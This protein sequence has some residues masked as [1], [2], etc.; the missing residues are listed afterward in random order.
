MDP[1]S[2]VVALGGIT[3]ASL[4][5]LSLR[6]QE[7]G[8][9]V[10][11]A[12]PAD[13]Y[14]SSVNESQSRYNMLTSLVNPLIN[15]LIPV[16][17]S[18]SE[19]DSTSRIVRQALGNIDAEYTNSDNRYTLDLKKLDNKYKPRSDGNDSIF[20]AINFC[21]K[22]GANGTPF[23]IYNTDGTVRREGA[24]SADGNFVFDEICGVCLSGGFDEEGKVFRGRRGLILDPNTRD[25]A[26]AD[27]QK[28]GLPYPRASPSLATCEGAPDKPVFATN[29]KDLDRFAKRLRCIAERNINPQHECGLCFQNDS[30][31]YVQNGAEITS[32]SLVLQ[33]FGQADVLLK[34]E[35]LQTITLDPNRSVKVELIGGKESDIFNVSV[36]LASNAPPNSIATVFGYIE[37]ITANGGSFQM[38]LNL[39]M[40]LDEITGSTPRKAG[41]F[42]NYI[43]INLDVAK[44]RPSAG[45]TRMNLRGTIP[46]T[47]VTADEFSA[48]D[49]P[50][51]PYQTNTASVSNFATD[52]PCY[53]KGSGPGKYND[54]CLRGRILD[55]GCTNKGTLYDDP[56][57]LNTNNGTNQN[58]TQIYTRLTN[59]YENDMIDP[60]K[61]KMCSGRTIDTPCDPFMAHPTL[62][63]T[64][65]ALGQK[66]VSFLYKNMGAN[67]PG[68]VKRIGP[69]YTAAIT[70]ANNQKVEKN[71]YCLP[72][73]TLNP[74]TNTTSLHTL[75]QYA[76]NG[77][78]GK[79]SVAAIKAYLNDQ[80]EIAIDMT[81]NANTDP[82]RKAAITRC[83]GR[84]LRSLPIPSQSKPTVTSIPC[85]VLG[86]Y[87]R[88]L[89]SLAGFGDNV[90]QIAQLVVIDKTGVNVAKGKRTTASA[91]WYGTAPK[92]RAN[93]GVM[94]ARPYDQIYHSQNTLPVGLGSTNTSVFW[95]V[96]L[97]SSLDITKII[98][99]NRTDCCNHRARGMRIQILDENMQIQGEQ[100]LPS[101]ELKQELNF[102]NSGVDRNVCLSDLKRPPEFVIPGGHKPGMFV[103]FYRC[104]SPNPGMNIGS[105]GWGPR[106]GTAN[107]YTQIHFQDHNL[108]QTDQCFV[109]AKG[110]FVSNGDETLQF[111]TISD[112]GIL[113][114]FNNQ[115]VISNWNIHGPTVNFSQEVYVEAPGIYP[116]ELR[117]YE[118]GGG[119]QCTLY[120]KTSQT[121]WSI[122]LNNRVYYKE[123]EVRAEEAAHQD[124]LNRAA[125]EK[126]KA[127][128]AAAAAKP[129]FTRKGCWNDTPNRALSGLQQWGHTPQSCFQKAMEAGV[130]QFALQAGSWCALYQNGNNYKRYGPSR[131]DCGAGGAGYVNTV[132]QINR[133]AVMYGSWIGGDIPVQNVDIDNVGNTVYMIEHDR[134]TKMVN[135]QGQAR[136]YVGS[137]GQYNSAYWN[138]YSRAD[139]NYLVRML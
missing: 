53:A 83:F 41:G 5:G 77:Y 43:D 90:I 22:E 76:D 78:N 40:V 18:K 125:A 58:L 117:F 37:S 57:Q 81:R 62:Q 84:S 39:V 73:G 79:T 88:V 13:K 65:N 55:V 44:M 132:Y 61:T 47:F 103:R 120:W 82:E 131:V 20:G 94:R 51:A 9:E 138:N 108:P 15:G 24:K 118:W 45:Q 105:A 127:E 86:R 66:C 102:I 14:D 25:E 87:V 1:I 30:Y 7:E 50:T 123:S 96:D 98:Y 113:L 48:M 49:C 130:D 116:F 69:T 104:D 8:F 70:Y 38:P 35:K 12:K 52:Q 36:Y 10:L 28:K 46:F 114:F 71:I 97:G 137:I 121:G 54:D 139:G 122:D 3:L 21:K 4:A 126:A 101:G 17:S 31:S 2:G 85:G 11:T 95:M 111:A 56:K 124:A 134:Y 106:I 135:R 42:F 63:F 23:T 109:S 60:E 136:Y 129:T 93:D 29:G 16:G 110:Y 19:V 99:Y 33:G 107:A 26:N 68:P 6:K 80:L 32:I 27:M 115:N 74:D 112:D 133:K 92:E 91:N 34:K 64:G 89:P 100:N 59:I 67:E 72:E 119:A 128:A 75:S